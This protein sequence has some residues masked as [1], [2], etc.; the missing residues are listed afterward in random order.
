[1]S[2]AESIPGSVY[3]VFGE[4]E[5][6]VE[7]MLKTLLVKIKG[8]FGEPPA[9]EAVD[10]QEGRVDEVLAEI[11]SPSLFAANKVTVLKR[12]RFGRQR[13]LI[14]EIESCISEGL[15]AGQVLVLVTSGVDKRLKLVKTI[16]RMGGLI[17][18]PELGPEDIERYILRRFREYGKSASRDVAQL[19]M[20]LKDNLRA[21]GSE[22]EKVV[23]YVGDADEV[24]V[25]DIERAVGRSKHEKVYELT[26]AVITRDSHGALAILSELI[27]RPDESPIGLLYRVSRE[28]RCLLQVRLFLDNTPSGWAENMQF[29]AFKK[30]V[31]PRFDEWTKDAGISR[32]DS[33][34]WQRPYGVYM[35]FKEGSGFA[36]ED[37]VR[38]LD[39]L[40]AANVELV[41]TSV[42][43]R[44]VLE[45][46][47]S[48]LGVENCSLAAKIS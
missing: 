42:D 31:L 27:D 26:R 34:L 7:E 33:Y 46:L 3:L 44:I 39:G 32:R 41:S 25:G 22:I 9:V 13:K 11:V 29:G 20:D 17:E 8:A 6:L 37:L 47:V 10:C 40:L 16:N 14:S 1:L 48:T 2:S 12:L 24:T 21:I 4:N 30:V 45:R 43:P 35:R 18:V 28:I 5:F 19:L 38:F 15:V 23:T 36:V